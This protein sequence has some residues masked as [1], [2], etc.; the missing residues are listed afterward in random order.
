MIGNSDKLLGSYSNP[1]Q[2]TNLWDF[3]FVDWR[4]E[5]NVMKVVNTNLPYLVTLETG[6]YDTLGTHFYNGFTFPESF[7]VTFREDTNF[8][9]YNYFKEWLDII[10]DTKE[11]TFKSYNMNSPIEKSREGFI[12]MYSYRFNEESINLKSVI[13]NKLRTLYENI[14]DTY[15]EKAKNLVRGGNI[16][17]AGAL[18]RTDT[19]ENVSRGLNE[20]LSNN[21]KYFDEIETKVF[22]LKG[23]RF[24]GITDS[25]LDYETSE[26][27][28]IT[29]NFSVDKVEDIDNINL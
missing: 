28:K 7:S 3:Y 8:T 22:K 6:K 21:K 10:F 4:G 11:A 20:A 16:N 1:A 25:N 14:S 29:V 27:L 2:L 23:I 18:F 17:I 26:E 5:M 13:D 9:V 12:V 15:V 19:F 24:L